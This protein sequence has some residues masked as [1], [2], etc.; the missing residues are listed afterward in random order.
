MKEA[1]DI[2]DNFSSQEV[3]VKRLDWPKCCLES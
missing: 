1:Y 3:E 2:I